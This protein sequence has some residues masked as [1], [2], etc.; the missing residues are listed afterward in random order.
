MVDCVV[1]GIGQYYNYVGYWISQYHNNIVLVIKEAYILNAL[2]CPSVCDSSSTANE[3]WRA[4]FAEA[5][6]YLSYTCNDVE[7]LDQQ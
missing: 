6:C 1:Y 5:D 2:F 4:V 3:L 7:V